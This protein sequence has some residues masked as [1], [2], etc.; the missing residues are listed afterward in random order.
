ML[1]LAHSV[2]GGTNACAILT[3]ALKREKAS[4]NSDIPLIF[5]LS[6]TSIDNLNMNIAAFS[7][8]IHLQHTEDLEDIANGLA[9]GKKILTTELQLLRIIK[10]M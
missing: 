4:L 7:D 8:Y 3:D 9:Y 2:S 1:W 5:P 6:G 10:Q